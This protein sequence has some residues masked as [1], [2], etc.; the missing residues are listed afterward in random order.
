[1]IEIVLAT[2]DNYLK[3]C[4]V[5]MFSILKNTTSKIRFH[6]FDSGV[7]EYAKQKILEYKKIFGCEISFYS[8]AKV[9]MPKFRLNREHITMPAYYRL[10]IPSLLS[11]TI[12]KAIYLDCDIVVNKDIKELWD[13]DIEKYYAGTI[14]DETSI[15]NNERLNLLKSHIYFNSGVLLLNLKKLREINLPEE[16]FK[17]YENNFEKIILNDQ[18]LLNGVFNGKCLNLPLKFNI[19][20]QMLAGQDGSHNY[21]KEDEKE[22][23][24]NGVIFHYTAQ[25]KPWLDPTIPYSD[26]FWHY[27]RQIDF[28]EEILFAN[29]N[30]SLIYDVVNYNKIY[31]KYLKYKFLKLFSVGINKT[32]LKD[33]ISNI[34]NKISKIR[35]LRKD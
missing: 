31:R 35:K 4:A 32:L 28:Y 2:D 19:N 24:E 7:S 22:A 3:Y 27:A 25:Q 5:C 16:C 34:K 10:Y 11:D 33:K 18:D 9:K 8:M 17:Y 6:I 13:Y 21:S 1:M 26:I 15:E 20:N 14:E 12:E 23:I 30:N 29:N